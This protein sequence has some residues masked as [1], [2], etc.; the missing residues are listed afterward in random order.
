[1][2]ADSAKSVRGLFNFF[3]VVRVCL[4]VLCG[5][6][7]TLLTF[8]EQLLGFTFPLVL[9]TGGGEDHGCDKKEG[10]DTGLHV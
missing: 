8:F 10:G 2:A 5:G 1:M 3:L 6:F 9:F 4:A 7:F